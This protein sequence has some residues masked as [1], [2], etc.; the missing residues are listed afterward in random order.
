MNG[1]QIL[2]AFCLGG[3]TFWSQNALA[4]QSPA[5]PAQTPPLPTPPTATLQFPGGNLFDYTKAMKEAAPAINIALLVPEAKEIRVPPLRLDAVA[6]SPA[7]E[8]L[9]GKYRIE[10]GSVVHLNVQQLDGSP[11]DV[12]GTTGVFKITTERAEKLKP[13]AQVRVWNIGELLGPDRKAQDVLTAVETAVGLLED[14]EPAKIRYHAETKLI[15]A[16]GEEE[17][18]RAIDRVIIGV[19]QSGRKPGDERS[20]ETKAKVQNWIESLKQNKAS[21]ESIERWEW[22]QRELVDKEQTIAQLRDRLQARE[23]SETG[24][25]AP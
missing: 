25:A 8:L 13:P 7:L 24:N 23:K 18:L 17:Q 15:V 14:Y 11:R 21:P 20:E 4:Q 5:T 22:V 19:R 9:Q 6:F 2:I 1:K 10:D 16:S 12:A 3:M